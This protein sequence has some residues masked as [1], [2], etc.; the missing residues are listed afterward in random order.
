MKS[1]WNKKLIIQLLSVGLVRFLFVLVIILMVSFASNLDSQTPKPVLD[2]KP[3]TAKVI[4]SQSIEKEYTAAKIEP[5]L[6]PVKGNK[7]ERLFHPIIIQT[8]SR[9]QVD[10]AIVK[11]I[12]MA[13]SGYNPRAIS[14]AG[15]KG[16]MQLMPNTAQALG[17]E[18]VFNP[19]QNISGGVRYFKQLLNRFNGDIELALAA[20]NA[21]SATVRRY[22]GVPPFK[23]TQH[24]IKKVFKYYQLY[25]NQMTKEVD[26]A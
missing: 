10:P 1:T 22:K 13:E 3:V 24:Y 7:K 15:A 8:S 11:A 5:I 21:G 20:Y 19:Q 25:K 26:R 2:D 18:D 4:S 17:V 14:K 16:L 9:H 12:I 6:P 23:A